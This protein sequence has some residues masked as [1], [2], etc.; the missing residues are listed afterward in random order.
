M[1]YLTLLNV[2][3]LATFDEFLNILYF[4]FVSDNLLRILPI[5]LIF[6]GAHR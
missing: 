2:L 3:I 5:S 4:K 1:W 6:D